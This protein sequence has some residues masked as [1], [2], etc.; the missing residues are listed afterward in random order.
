VDRGL[1]AGFTDYLTKPLNLD[2]F[3]DTVSRALSGRSH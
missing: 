3:M 2:Q 1:E